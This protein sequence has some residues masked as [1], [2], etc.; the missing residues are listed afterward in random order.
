MAG[1]PANPAF[2]FGCDEIEETARYSA[3]YYEPT[4]KHCSGGID[5]QLSGLSSR[6]SR[7]RAAH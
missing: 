7:H 3:D 5:I 6:L 2:L 4:L 1:A